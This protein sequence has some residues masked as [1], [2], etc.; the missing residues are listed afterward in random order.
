MP[1]ITIEI[2]INASTTNIACLEIHAIKNCKNIPLSKLSPC[3]IHKFPKDSSAN[4][5]LPMPMIDFDM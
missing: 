4:P 3:H 2:E 5:S 1:N